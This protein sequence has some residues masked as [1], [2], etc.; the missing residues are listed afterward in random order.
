MATKI[1]KHIYR[2]KRGTEKA[3]FTNNPVLMDGEPLVVICEDNIVRLKIGDGKTAYND[4]AFV[5]QDND[6]TIQFITDKLD[7]LEKSIHNAGDFVYQLDEVSLNSFEGETLSD[8]ITANI[9]YIDPLVRLCEGNIAI[10]KKVLKQNP[11]QYDY[12]AY[13][14]DGTSWVAMS[15]NYTADTI[16]FDEDLIYTHPVG[17]LPVPKEGHG[18]IS[19]KGK[20]LKELLNQILV[21]RKYPNVEMPTAVLM[22]NIEG[23]YE[24]GTN[25]TVSYEFIT[26]VGSYEYESH[27]GV[28]FN[29]AG[30]TFNGQY[31]EGKKG[32]FNTVQVVDGINLNIRG[33]ITQMA[34]NIPKDNL[35]DDYEEGR[36]PAK[37]HSLVTEGLLTGFRG[38]FFGYK[39]NQDMLDIDLIESNHIR[40]LGSGACTSLPTT[41]ETT[42]MQQM[43]FAVPKGQ[44]QTL[45]VE[46]LGSGAPQTVKKKS[47][48]VK[49][50]NNYA[51]NNYPNGAEYDLFYVSN[52]N[53]N[54][55][56]VTYK[57]SIN[58][59]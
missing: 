26:T 6:K 4:L 52:T 53:P 39:T 7:D 23:P 9:L 11:I 22:T 19:A 27:T 43:F 40:A 48:Y 55:G 1:V 29:N 32:T 2:L 38:I 21:E 59:V 30:A 13:I 5:S 36:I 57:I 42:D 45:C 46:Q 14:Y 35:G 10:I 15:G 41:I 28:L 25:V 50:A 20:S 49:G 58:I 44:I 8:K 17:N 18:V 54:S 56:N 12:T 47:V 24:V 34:G 16:V 33:S 37:L 31:V 51:T 3:L